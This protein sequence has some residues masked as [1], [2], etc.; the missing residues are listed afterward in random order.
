[1]SKHLDLPRPPATGR[2]A[3]RRGRLHLLALALCIALPACAPLAPA[4]QTV[5]RYQCEGGQQFLLSIAATGD[6]ATIELAR[7]RFSLRSEA[8]SGPGQRYSCD[9]LSVWRDGERAKVDMQ[10]APHL[11]DCWLQR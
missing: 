11:A 7:M 10:D 9:V 1:M 3:D 8:A 4:P 5:L 2:N 6:G